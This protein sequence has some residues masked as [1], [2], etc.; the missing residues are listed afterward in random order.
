MYLQKTR[1]NPTKMV[2]LGLKLRA[3][4]FELDE[5]G[6]KDLPEGETEQY[7]IVALALHSIERI[8]LDAYKSL[9]EID[10]LERLYGDDEV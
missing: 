8:A 1:E 10:E 3:K 2:T 7:M 9:Q 6:I 4:L 5:T